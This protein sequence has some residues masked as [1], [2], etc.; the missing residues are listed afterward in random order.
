MNKKALKQAYRMARIIRAM[1]DYHWSKVDTK[2]LLEAA[3][4]PIN[5]WHIQHFVA[6][7]RNTPQDD[8]KAYA[9][10]MYHQYKSSPYRDTR[11]RAKHV[12]LLCI[13][14]KYHRPFRLPS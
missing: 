7:S 8:P 5:D 13:S 4:A 1:P 10:Q 9:M 3:S 2:N 14:R 6:F 12:F 11:D